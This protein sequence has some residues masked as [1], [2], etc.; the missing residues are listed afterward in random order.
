V[1]SNAADAV[2][3]YVAAARGQPWQAIEGLER[4]RNGCIET[5]RVGVENTG[6]V[7]AFKGLR[8]ANYRKQFPASAE[9]FKRYFSAHFIADFLMA[10]GRRCASI[11]TARRLDMVLYRDVWKF[12]W[13]WDGYAVLV[14]CRLSGVDTTGR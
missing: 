3:V 12:A 13:A 6:T 5:P 8:E 7:V 11:S 10:K 14:R 4:T 2:F 1:P 9:L